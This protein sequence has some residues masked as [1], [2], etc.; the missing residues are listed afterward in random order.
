MDIN[1]TLILSA[2]ISSSC[3]YSLTL[4]S[5][6]RFNSSIFFV[7]LKTCGV[8]FF[9]NLSFLDLGRREETN[10]NFYS[11]T[12]LW[13]L[14]GT[15]KKCKNKNLSEQFINNFDFFKRSS[16][17]PWKCG[18]LIQYEIPMTG[19][20]KSIKIRISFRIQDGLEKK[21][22][23]HLPMPFRITHFKGKDYMPFM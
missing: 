11:S 12:S 18:S 17:M 16:K 9:I 2:L 13:C 3:A 10:W 22:K 4:V 15:T 7:V 5:H 23:A 6:S 21:H 20:T 8:N 14:R 19:E 1:H